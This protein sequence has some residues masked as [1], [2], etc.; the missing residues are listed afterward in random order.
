MSEKTEQPTPKRIRDARKKGQVAKSKEVPSVIIIL[1]IVGTLFLMKD[2]YLEHLET[3][4]ILP[5]EFIGQP[6]SEAI[7]ILLPKLLKEMGLLL[8]PI[9]AIA[10]IAALIGNIAQT[11]MLFSVDPIVP[12][13]EKI[14]PVKGV[15][16]MVSI[17]NLMEL[18]KSLLKVTILSLFVWLVLHKNM[19]TLLDIHYCGEDCLLPI[20]GIQLKQLLLYSSIGFMLIAGA[21]FMFERYQHRKQLRMSKDEVK[22]EFKETEGNP[23]I[24]GKRRQLH[25]ELQSS[26]KKNVKNSSVIVTN[27]THVSVGLCY[28]R[29]ITPLPIV[30]VQGTDARAKLIRR[31]AEQEGIPIMQQVPLARTLLADTEPGDYIPSEL[32]QPVAEVLK[33][34]EQVKKQHS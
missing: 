33:W 27:P 2:F 6:F 21:D 16:R 1:A 18:F 14:D 13:F 28:E 25:Q 4:M 24:K 15:K 11:G 34:A 12:K 3:L 10:F 22:R 9:L 8:A 23:E 20:V 17:K 30:T 26:V 7:N 32:I 29:G 5:I 31:I 19:G